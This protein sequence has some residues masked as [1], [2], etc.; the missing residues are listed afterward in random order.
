[1]ISFRFILNP[2]YSLDVYIL[3]ERSLPNFQRRKKKRLA[4]FFSEKEKGGNFKPW[5]S[6]PRA[7]STI[8]ICWTWMTSP[9][10]IS[11]GAETLCLTQECVPPTCCPVKHSSNPMVTKKQAS[12]STRE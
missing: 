2:T 6:S 12:N 1:M 7:C 8:A 10:G 11:R 4:Y 9:Q 3:L 5:V